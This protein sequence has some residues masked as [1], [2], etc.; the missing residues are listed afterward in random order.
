[1]IFLRNSINILISNKVSRA[2]AQSLIGTS[3]LFNIF[4]VT[5][6]TECKATLFTFTNQVPLKLYNPNKLRH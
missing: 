4:K 5:K 3:L 2:Y 6:T 1:M